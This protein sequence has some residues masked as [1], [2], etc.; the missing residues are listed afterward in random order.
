MSIPEAFG[1]Y[2]VKRLLGEG[3]FGKV[4]LAHDPLLDRQVAVKV[5]HGEW[6]AT[7]ELLAEARAL[8][9]LS[10]PAIV[11]VLDAGMDGRTAFLV[12]EHVDGLSLEGVMMRSRGP[13]EPAHAV[14]LLRDPA[15]AIDH[16]HSKGV[17]HGDLKPANLLAPLTG[18]LLG[19]IASLA[20]GLKVVDVGL[21]TLAAHGGQAMA[22]GDPRYAAPE[23]WTGRPSRASDVFS[24]AAVFFHLVAG[25]PPLEGSARDLVEAAATGERR[26]LRAA[27]PDVAAALDDAVAAALSPDAAERPASATALVEALATS[28]VE[29]TTRRRIVRDAR[30]RIAAREEPQGRTTCPSC[31][32]AVH[33]RATTCPHCGDPA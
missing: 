10:H 22:F 15:A 12:L 11:Q 31:R 7:K 24:L 16:A 6:L 19:G 29:S 8:A 9:K 1:R 2:R 32:R 18:P 21:M 33:P 14:D 4:W 20:S 28:L 5:P 25:S 30:E 27:R 23:A 3:G 13:A 26:R 17:L